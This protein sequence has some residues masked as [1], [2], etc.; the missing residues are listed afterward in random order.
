MNMKTEVERRRPSMDP[1][2]WNYR[3][4]KLDLHHRYKGYVNEVKS[5]INAGMSIARGK[6][7]KPDSRFV[8]FGRERSGSTLLVRYLDQHSQIHC[9]GEILR[10]RMLWPHG[11]RDRCLNAGTKPVRGFKLLSY[12]VTQ[13]HGQRPDGGYLKRLSEEGFK[14]IYL[15]RDNYFRLAVS[16]IYA[17][18]RGAFHQ[19]AS[20]SAEAKRESFVF[21]P[22]VLVNW[23]EGAELR[24]REEL[25]LLEDV[26]FLEVEYE[27]DLSNQETHLRTLKRVFDWLEVEPEPLS[28]ALKRI[29]PK[30]LDEIIENYDEVVEAVSKTR[31]ER[32][33]EK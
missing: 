5:L 29:T 23:M 4:P 24:T 33:L 11:H 16:N 22:K 7:S 30:R 2:P 31:Y 8:I 27:R 14:V 19:E 17:R 21:D 28:L 32:F 9:C 20:R 25:K 1:T 13:V 26:D 10:S 18:L 12:Q 3:E 6:Y 15:H